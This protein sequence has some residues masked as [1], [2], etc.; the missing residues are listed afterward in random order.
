MC[1]GQYEVRATGIGDQ[2]ERLALT[3]FGK[4]GDF[5]ARAFHPRRCGVGSL[6]AGI[7]FEQDHQWRGIFS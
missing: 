3:G 7:G 1:R 5:Q 6:H 4:I 2:A